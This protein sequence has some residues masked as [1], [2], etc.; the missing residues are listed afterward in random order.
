MEELKIIYE[1]I[2]EWENSGRIDKKKAYALRKAYRKKYI[3]LQKYFGSKSRRNS[4]ERSF[5]YEMVKEI[6]ENYYMFY[7]IEKLKGK[8]LT[9]YDDSYSFKRKTDKFDHK[10][11]ILNKYWK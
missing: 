3:E 4:M 6:A 10:L 7:L 11:W 1:K 5:L 2:R 8:D 9:V